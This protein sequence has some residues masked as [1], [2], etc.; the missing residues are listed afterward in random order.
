MYTLD[1]LSNFVFLIVLIDIG[2]SK[3]YAEEGFLIIVA[4][5]FIVMKFIVAIFGLM[6]FFPVNLLVIF[7]SFCKL[8]EF[9]KERILTLAARVVEEGGTFRVE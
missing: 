9:W 5:F 2:F 8:L 3:I 6:L 4:F 7:F 1:L